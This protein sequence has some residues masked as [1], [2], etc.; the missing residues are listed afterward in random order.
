MDQVIGDHP[1]LNFCLHSLITWS[2]I[3]VDLRFLQDTVP[4]DRIVVLRG[5]WSLFGKG[6][7]GEILLRLT[8]KAYVEEEEDARTNVKADAFNDEMSVSKE[9]GSFVRKEKVS[10]DDVGQESFMDVLSALIVSDE[11]QGIVSSEAGD[12]KLS[13]GSDSREVP[14]GLDTRSQ[15]ADPSNGF[16]SESNTV[17]SNSENS[18]GGTEVQCLTMIPFISFLDL[19][20]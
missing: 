10:S 5:G 8:Y 3:Q 11:F 16:E 2:Y 4:T 14:A 17:V 20:P 12:N 19:K 6:S 18:G 1:D 15:H 13:G 9:P 7:A